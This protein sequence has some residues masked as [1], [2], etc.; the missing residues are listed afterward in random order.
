MVIALLTIPAAMS[1]QFTHDLKK[2][3]MLSIIFS[4]IFTVGGLWL[5]YFLNWPSG[6]TI[7]LLGVALFL[8]SLAFSRLRRG[9]KSASLPQLPASS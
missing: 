8:A 1:R 6:A 7:I 9:G 4:I 5:S 3:M 2:M